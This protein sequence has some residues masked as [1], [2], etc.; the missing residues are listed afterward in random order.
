MRGSTSPSPCMNKLYVGFDKDIELPKR[1][2]LFIDDEVPKIPRARVFDVK[3]DCFNPLKNIDHKNAREIGEIL[4]TAYPEGENTL[5][6]RNGKRALLQLL[7]DKPK[8]LDKIRV[9]L[10]KAQ[11]GSIEAMETIGDV[12]MSP[13]LK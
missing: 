5:T 2:F 7:T 6:V 4:Y 9:N 12:L 8:R 10:A 11:A 1:G 13:V 3:T